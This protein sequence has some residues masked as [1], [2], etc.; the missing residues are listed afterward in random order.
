MTEEL[1]RDFAKGV[2]KFDGTDPA[3]LIDL[4]GGLF[5]GRDISGDLHGSG[6]AL[7]HIFADR[8]SVPL[9]PCG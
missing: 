8:A 1:P 9:S 2:R 5:V 7:R 4:G 6:H 3:A